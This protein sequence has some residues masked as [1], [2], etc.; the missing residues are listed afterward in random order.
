VKRGTER[1]PQ[2]TERGH[3]WPWIH[4]SRMA[5][6]PAF[7]IVGA[8]GTGLYTSFPPPDYPNPDYYLQLL[9]HCPMPPADVSQL[10][11][12][13]SAEEDGRNRL[14][15][16]VLLSAQNES[17]AEKVVMDGIEK[18]TKNFFGV[19]M[20]PR[21]RFRSVILETWVKRWRCRRRCKD[22]L[23]DGTTRTREYCWWWFGLVHRLSSGARCC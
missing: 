17:L 12:M 7:S 4:L 10:F 15:V 11:E 19:K 23:G 1:V 13:I 2:A 22:V 5:P 14:W 18:E 3:G 16:M 21:D 9:H 20:R 8:V 6:K